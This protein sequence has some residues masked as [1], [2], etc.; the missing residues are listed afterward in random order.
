LTTTPDLLSARRGEDRYA[1]E[2]RQGELIAT[3]DESAWG[4]NGP[5][6]TL[7]ADRR[8]DF[9]IRQARLAPGVSCLEL[10][11]GTG[12]FTQRLVKSNCD[13]T[14]VE[15]SEATAQRCR[16]R[17]GGRA[18]VVLGNIETGEGLT[19]MQFDAIVGVSVLH[20][21]NLEL[22][23]KNTFALLKPGGRFA[24]VEPNM[25]NPQVWA[26]RHIGIVK[27]MRHVTAH[28]TAFIAKRL[29]ADFERAGLAVDICEPFEFLHP[30]TPGGL[31]PLVLTIERIASATPLRAIAGS[32]RISG[33]KPRA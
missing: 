14:A 24:F 10:G 8:G 29:R 15:I 3:T 6:G 9:M 26:E 18:K 31:M 32:V 19:G 22:C 27:K 17:V 7:R 1:E 20:H 11:C 28:E 12:E 5:A 16:E 30:S 25:A 13:L 23:F 33:Y 2:R 21:L 4:W